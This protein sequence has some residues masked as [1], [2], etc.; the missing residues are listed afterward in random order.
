VK[1]PILVGTKVYL[2]PLERADAAAVVPWFNDPDVSRFSLRYRPLTLQEQEQW[3]EQ[4]GRDERSVLLGIA[5]REDDRLIG[6]TGFHQLSFK[7]RGAVFGILIGAKAEWDKGYGSEATR[8][9]VRYAFETLNLH[10]VT[11]YVF[12]YNARAIR[13]YEKIGFRRE[14]LLRQENWREGRYWDTIVMG[15]LRDEWLAV[16]QAAP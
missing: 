5:L 11:L 7:D 1:N 16:Q 8:L 3:L 10:R 2:R 9:M 6:T 15:L 12:E 14:G 4:A 13:T